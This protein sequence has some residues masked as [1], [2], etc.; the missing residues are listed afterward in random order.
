[1]W[2][3]R[4]GFMPCAA[5][6]TWP[7]MVWPTSSFATPARATTSSS[8]AGAELVRGHAR[9]G[10]EEAAHGRARGRGDD[11]VRSWGSSLGG[12]QNA[13]AGRGST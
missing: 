12:G 6:S 13:A 5:V 2:A 3:W 1:M 9:E 8:T 7:R 10:A 4:A 11:D